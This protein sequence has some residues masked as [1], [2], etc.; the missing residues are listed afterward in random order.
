MIY[1]KLGRIDFQSSVVMFGAAKLGH[2]EQSEAEAAIEY[3]LE[4]QVNHFDTAASYGHAEV[5]MGPSMVNIRDR[6]FLATKTGERDRA[7]AKAEIMRSLEKLQVVGDLNELDLC[8]RRGGALEALLEAKEEGLLKHIGITGHGHSAPHTHLEALKRYPFD[9]VLLPLNYHFY[10]MPDYREA[11]DQLMEE[12]EQQQVAVRAIKA[13]AKGPWGEDLKMG[14]RGMA[15]GE[16][17]QREWNVSRS[18]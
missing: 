17:Y 16:S 6:I 18:N 9:T 5:R 3:A 14:I 13:I 11:F 15:N 10:Q 7:A 8:T 2:V 1:R 12:A 4:H